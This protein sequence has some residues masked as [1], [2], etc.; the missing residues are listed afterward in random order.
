M[1]KKI[2]AGVLIVVGIILLLLPRINGYLLKN[3]SS[4]EYISEVTHEQMK[5]NLEN[6]EATFDFDN[7]TPIDITSTIQNINSIN[8]DQIVAQ[9]IIPDLNMNIGIFLGV[10]NANLNSGAG[11]L[12][13]DQTLGE[14]NYAI[15]AHYSGYKDVLFNRIHDAAPGMNAYLTD[16]DKIYHYV[17]VENKKVPETELSMIENSQADA[18]GAPILSMMTCESISDST[19]RIFAIATLKDTYEYTQANIE[20]YLQ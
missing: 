6:K 1:A 8:K 11:T 17:I 15:A 3:V 9:L 14:G 12:K 5:K 4:K 2:I 18:Y 16:K 13:P 19:N 20:K 10:S 7:V